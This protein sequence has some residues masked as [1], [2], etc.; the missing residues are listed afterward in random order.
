MATSTTP[1]VYQLFFLWIEPFFTILGTVCAFFT[2]GMYIEMTGASLPQSLAAK[3]EIAPWSTCHDPR[4]PAP[5]RNMYLIFAI[6]EAFVL[7]ATNDLRVWRVLL[8]GLLIADFGH[9]FSLWPLG[10]TIYYNIPNWN[11][12]GLGQYWICVCWSFYQDMLLVGHG[13]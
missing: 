11:A 12:M 9:L 6:N 7:R 13:L 2:P 8:I 5:A 3:A 10:Y 4:G 1:L